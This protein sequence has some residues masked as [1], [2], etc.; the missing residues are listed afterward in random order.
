MKREDFK[1]IIKIRSFYKID[2]R[3]GDYKL[4]S[5]DKL[6]V[7]VRKLVDQQLAL[8]KLF[9]RENGNLCFGTGGDVRGRIWTWGKP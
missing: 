6:S 7:Y 5:G 9:I 4:P 1:K 8:D 2:R 3:K